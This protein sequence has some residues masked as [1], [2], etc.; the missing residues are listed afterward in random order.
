M[1]ADKAPS[2]T[3]FAKN[4]CAW[5]CF[6]CNKGGNAIRLVQE[7]YGIGFTEACVW[8]ASQYNLMIDAPNARSRAYKP[9]YTTRYNAI[10]QESEDNRQ[11]DV[12]VISTLL[13][14]CTLTHEAK[15][16]LFEQRHLSPEVIGRLGIVGISDVSS[17]IKY[18][19]SR[20]PESRLIESGI[21]KE[22]KG[23]LYI[24]FWTPCLIFPYRDIDGILTGI[25]TRYIGSEK[26]APRFQ[27]IS[28]FKTS[29]FNLQ[30]LQS[31]KPKDKLFISE[32]IT[33]CLA[34]LSTGKNAVAIPSASI[35]PDLDLWRLRI[36]DLHMYPDNDDAGI[37]AYETLLSKMIDN[38]SYIWKESV[39]HQFKDYSEYYLSISSHD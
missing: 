16:F 4:R 9:A 35:L 1:H 13:G 7:Y 17:V 38:S 10:D 21:I 5:N 25:Q 33:D 28:G 12:E 15:E 26:S 3:F 36:Y 27:F 24:R 32:G 11:F 31:L 2:L 29:V 6:S 14:F 22:T 19:T 39:P 23:K 37:K 20:Y 8:L 30:I 18:L 34:L